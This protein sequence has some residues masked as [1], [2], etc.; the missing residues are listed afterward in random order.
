MN[1]LPMERL[2][3]LLRLD[4]D[5]GLL[6]WLVDCPNGAKLGHVAG[7]QDR[8][9]YIRVEIDQVKLTAHRVVWALHTGCWPPDDMHIDHIN[10]IKTDN[11]PENL[12][13][14]DNSQNQSSAKSRPGKS[15]L[16]GV[17][18]ASAMGKWR[19]KIMK[20]KKTIHVGYFD[21]KQKAH[22]AYCEASKEIHGEF[23]NSS[24]WG[25]GNV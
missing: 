25:P 15:G 24:S 18:W 2:R 14:A 16:R 4:P 17:Y 13:L 12:R 3:S 6:Y 23:R 20:D 8:N 19:A 7:S 22:D 1:K 9:R 5:T 10:G 11:R 21:D